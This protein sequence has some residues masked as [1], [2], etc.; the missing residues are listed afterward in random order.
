MTESCAFLWN[1]ILEL[2]ELSVE[3]W[4]QVFEVKIT[5]ILQIIT[6]CTI[7]STHFRILL[8]LCMFLL[9][10]VGQQKGC[11]PETTPKS[12]LLK[13]GQSGLRPPGFSALPAS[14]LAAFGFIQSS[15]IS[16]VNSNQSSDSSQGDPC[17]STQRESTA[18]LSLSSIAR[19][20]SGFID[21]FSKM[22]HP[23]S[24][25]TASF[26]DVLT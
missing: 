25:D 23:L 7:L 16:S 9:P 8:P 18:V 19:T 6:S 2:E 14:R 12:L 26:C 17:R 15:S 13:S 10:R 22:L 5:G 3:S 20:T 11:G 24:F 21:F 4:L 1:K